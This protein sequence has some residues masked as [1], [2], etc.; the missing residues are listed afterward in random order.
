MTVFWAAFVFGTFWFWAL[1]IIFLITAIVFTEQESGIGALITLAIYAFYIQ[2]L[3]K[4]NFVGWILEQPLNFL[5]AI[6]SYLI[7][8][9]V[10]SCVKWWLLVSYIAEIQKDKWAT[11]L[12]NH[13]LSKDTKTL[14]QNLYKDW[15][16]KKKS[17]EKPLFRHN[18]NKITLWVTYWPLSMVYSLIRDFLVKITRQIVIHFQG[19]YEKITSNAFKDLD[20]ITVDKK[21][22]NKNKKR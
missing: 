8:G 18:K 9:L 20:K 2:L 11:F 14:P 19:V 3:A 22:S 10:W 4:V 1:S 17:F 12:K 21:G 7:I 6:G 16:N 13:N 15:E 5:I